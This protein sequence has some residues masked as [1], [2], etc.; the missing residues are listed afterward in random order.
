MRMGIVRGTVVL[1]TGDPSLAGTR[2]LLVEVM[3]ADTLAGQPPPGGGPMLVVA[4]HLSPSRGE[5][6]AFVEG[7]EA[8]NA[9]W[10][11]Q[12]PVDAYSSLI[13][14]RIDYRPVPGGAGGTSS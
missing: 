11:R 1:G 2:F 3:T 10:P 14:D 8:A 13:V 7:R 9:Y 4:D 5:V 6:I 12:A